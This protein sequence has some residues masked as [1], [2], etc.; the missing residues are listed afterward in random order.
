MRELGGG[1]RNM[2]KLSDQDAVLAQGERERKVR[3]KGV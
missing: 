3:V 2:E 1:Q